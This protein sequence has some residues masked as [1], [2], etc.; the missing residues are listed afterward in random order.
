MEGIIVEIQTGG[1]H[2]FG[3]ALLSLFKQQIL[4]WLETFV[5]CVVG[6]HRRALCVLCRLFNVD[7]SHEK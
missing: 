3:P 6:Y 7:S 2:R 1:G 5:M 4:R